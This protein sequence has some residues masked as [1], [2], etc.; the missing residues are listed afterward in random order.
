M[1]KSKYIFET[2]NTR[3]FR[4][5]KNLLLLSIVALV[6]YVLFAFVLLLFSESENAKTHK[7]FFKRSPDLISVF[8]GDIGRI[9]YAIKFAQEFKHSHIFITGVY[10]KNSVET[11]LS[12]MSING[13]IDPNLLTIDYLARNTVENVIAT[14]R[15]LRKNKG[16]DQVLIISSDYHIM[17]IKLLME[18][19][20]DSEDNFQFQYLGVKTDYK[21]P[22]N[23]KIVLKEVYKLIRAY[24]FVLLWE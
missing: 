15:H 4:Y 14:L 20:K 13:Q 17:R 7:A 19:L 11:L 5:F 24:I 6:F 9:P 8:T 16:M 12:P 10:S 23:I 21:R 3:Y 22:R 18:Q 1:F 2:N